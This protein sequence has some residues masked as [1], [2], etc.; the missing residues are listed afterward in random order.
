MLSERA[1]V[2]RSKYHLISYTYNGRVRRNFENHLPNIKPNL[3]VD[4]GSSIGK[5]TREISDIYPEAKVIGMDVR[6]WPLWISNLINRKKIS[7]SKIELLHGDGY[8]LDKYFEP[9]SID[10]LFFMNTLFNCFYCN[11][12]EWS[13]LDKLLEKLSPSI[14]I[15][16]AKDIMN[17]VDIVVKNG[18]YL[19]SSW[20]NYVGHYPG[21]NIESSIIYRKNENGIWQRTYPNESD[22][23]NMIYFDD[24]RYKTID[25]IVLNRKR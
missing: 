11:K 14:I 23:D 8:N 16:E 24:A 5:T 4:V 12:T 21:A 22:K 17:K 25:D 7:E 13:R 20:T 3:V 9:Q 19:L 2:N 10:I 18:G 6:G 15:E 1:L